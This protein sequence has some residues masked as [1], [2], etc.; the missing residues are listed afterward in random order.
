MT[1]DEAMQ[2]GEVRQAVEELERELA[3]DRAPGMLFM[4]FELKTVLEDFGAAQAAL[5]E[6]R[7]LQPHTAPLL[8]DLGLCLASDRERALRRN[9]PAMAERR[10]GVGAPAPFQLAL[11]KAAVLYAQKDKAGAAKAVNEARALMPHASGTLTPRAGEKIRFLDLSDSDD[12]VGPSIEIVGPEGV[13][14]VSFAQVRSIRLRDINGLQ[15]AL[16]IPAEVETSDGQTIHTRLPSQYPGSGNHGLPQ[17]RLGGATMWDREGG[18]TIGF[19]QRDLR[20]I[21]PAGE[22]MV[23]L[24]QVARLDFDPPA[25]SAKKGFW[26]KLFS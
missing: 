16:W 15:D 22:T 10:R 11:V 6:L 9:T 2:H 25:T 17:V 7:R 14:D 20:L 26:Q 1:F 12:L 4:L 3:K 5:D 8:D 24:R 18:I 13:V 21:T 23:G 19:G